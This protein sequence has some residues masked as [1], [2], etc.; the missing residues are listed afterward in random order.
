MSSPSR[1]L[2]DWLVLAG[3]CGFLFFFGISSFGLIGPDEPR[4]AQVAR[5]MLARHDWITPTLDGKPWLEKPIFYYWQAILAY[6]IF[7]VKDWAARLPS[8]VDTTLMILAVYLFLRRFRLGFHLDGALIVAATAGIIGFARAASMDMPMAAAFT[9]AMLGWY[10]WFESG[11]RLYLGGCYF[12]LALAALAKGPVAILLAV[13]L[14]STFAALKRDYRLLSPSLWFPGIL[15]FLVVTLPWYVAVQL[16]NPDFFRTFILEQN[17]A[18]YGTNLYGHEQP[19]W[20]YGPVA[21]LALMPWT[22][23]VVCATQRTIRKLWTEKIS[24]F[25][26]AEALNVFLVIWLLLPIIFFSISRSKLPGYILPALPAGG[27]L[28]AEYVRTHSVDDEHPS[29][30]L[31]ILHSVI[32]AITIVPAVLLPYIVLQHRFPW[33]RTT[34]ILFVF[35]V[36]LAAAFIFTLRSRAGLRMLRFVTLIPVVLSVAAVLKIGAP[37]LDA[38]LSARPLAA[39]IARMETKTLPLAVFLVPRDTQYG[40]HFYRD[41]SIVRYETG[42]IPLDEHLLVAPAGMQKV[43]A[44]NVPGR[45][46]S[47]LGSFPA[48]GLDYYWVAPVQ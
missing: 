42:A 11:S 7:G 10:A 21:L 33:N 22:I 2:T 19:F 4:Y 38:V 24:T 46:V 1:P 39:E 25:Q 35:A 18:R 23:F 5:E 43:V 32:A 12:F 29:L 41:Q 36:G 31:I 26:C 16:R 27:L 9:I 17:L 47:Y 28:L 44:S 34:A 48:K 37:T 30:T 40:L 45:R 14:I 8:A 6:K 20:F 3:F 15:L 13:L